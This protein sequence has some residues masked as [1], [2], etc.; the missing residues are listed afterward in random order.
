MIECFASRVYLHISFR[1]AALRELH[2]LHR[3]A[4]VH[5]FEESDF[6]DHLAAW[7][8]RRRLWRR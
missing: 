4:E 8:A 3:E 2:R 1:T 7:K 6:D 5:H